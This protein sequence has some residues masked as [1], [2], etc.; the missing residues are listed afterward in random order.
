MSPL[1]KMRDRLDKLDPRERRLLSLL[2][3]VFGVMVLLGAPL[4]LTSSLASKRDENAELREAIAAIKEGRETVRART[5]KREAMVARYANKAPA[6]AGL[7][8]KAAREQQIEI[9]ESQDRPEV[10][11]GKKYVER[12]VVVRLRKV[13]MLSLARMLEMLEQQKMPISI[14]RLNIRKRGGEHDSYDVEIGV[15][16]FDRTEASSSTVP[17]GQE[18]GGR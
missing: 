7:L 17:A 6:L 1:A 5:I 13:T 4:L 12:G 15:S 3:V 8:E 10:P 16:A 14:G 11:H 18:G 2:G 9:P